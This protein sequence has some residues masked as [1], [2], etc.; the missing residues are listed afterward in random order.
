MKK[1]V[2]KDFAKFTEKPVLE[3]LFNKVAG[4]SACNFIKKKRQPRCFPVKSAKF[5]R[6]PILKNV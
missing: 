5:L 3:S 4:L 1:G 2:F 6:A